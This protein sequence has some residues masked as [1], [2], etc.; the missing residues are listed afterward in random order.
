MR[1][2]ALAIAV[3]AWVSLALQAAVSWEALGAPGPAALAWR[4]AAYFTVLTNLLAALAYS[5]IA[6]GGR[7]AARPLAALTVAMIVVSAVYHLVLARLW[8][9][10]GLAW[11]ADQGLHS[12]TPALVLLWWL[13]YAPKAG[14]RAGD[15]LTW[16]AWPACYLGY[17][18][19][20]QVLTGFA[21]YPFIDL[22]LH[23]AAGV[24]G[25]IALVAAAFLATGALL[26]LAARAI[27]R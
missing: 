6:I 17:A 25:N 26:A 4:Q 11:L 10:Q 3:T 5:A 1:A 19:T 27:S 14:V 16:L 8:N 18:M 13:V 23:G 7:L 24:A 12:A 2:L 15:F 22:S 20:R 9:P 21:P